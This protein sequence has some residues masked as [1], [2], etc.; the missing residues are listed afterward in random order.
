MFEWIVVLW[1]LIGVLQSV[2]P[3]VIFY[4]SLSLMIYVS[5]SENIAWQSSS[6]TLHWSLAS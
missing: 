3:C 4:D 5:M 6:V 2:L 1:Y